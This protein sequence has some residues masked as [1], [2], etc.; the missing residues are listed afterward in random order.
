MAATFAA[1]Q[2]IGDYLEEPIT[3]TS[4]GLIDREFN[5][6]NSLPDH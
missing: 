6:F 1:F 2:I 4:A 3:I 5:G